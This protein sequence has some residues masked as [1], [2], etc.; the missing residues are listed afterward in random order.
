MTFPLNDLMNGWATAPRDR[1]LPM[2]G[3]N[4]EKQIYTAFATSMSARPAG[5][6]QAGL[7]RV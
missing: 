2:L 6:K 1:L 4:P 7:W 3:Q 5:R